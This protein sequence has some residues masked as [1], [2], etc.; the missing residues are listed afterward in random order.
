[1]VQ[2]WSGHWIARYLWSTIL[3]EKICTNDRGQGDRKGRPYH[4]RMKTLQPP[5][6][7]GIPGQ[8]TL[9]LSPCIRYT[10]PLMIFYSRTGYWPETP[11]VLMNF[12]TQHRSC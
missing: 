11:V 8:R 2:S 6:G 12:P 5:I 4:T 7:A 1:M 9:E 3:R 10:K